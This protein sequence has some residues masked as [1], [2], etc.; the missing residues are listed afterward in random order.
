M[1]ITWESAQYPDTLKIMY[2]FFLMAV[3]DL[4][5]NTRFGNPITLYIYIY[6]QIS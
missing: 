6:E 3:L 1:Q 5:I 4:Q 2:L